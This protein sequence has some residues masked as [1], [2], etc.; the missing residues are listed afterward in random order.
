MKSFH[1]LCRSR[2]FSL[3]ELLLVLASILMLA[4]VAFVMFPMV[5]SSWHS[6]EIKDD[7]GVIASCTKSTFINRYDTI[8]LPDLVVAGCFP[9]SMTGNNPDRD[10]VPVSPWASE[11]R[12]SALPN[13]SYFMISVH[14]VKTSVCQKLVPLIIHSYPIVYVG[15][16]E[17]DSNSTGVEILSACR[18]SPEQQ[19]DIVSD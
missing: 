5:R 9:V 7:I 14:N 12:V 13:R 11:V 17:L 10:V 4:I 16:A 18:S 3:I 1:R 6:A 8:N 2:G 15:S 19:I